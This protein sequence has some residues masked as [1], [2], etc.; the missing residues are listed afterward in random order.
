MS[1]KRIQHDQ[2]HWQQL[3]EQQASSGLSG[4]AFCRQQDIRYANF[5]S[6]RKKLQIP[7]VH[8]EVSAQSAF[9]ELTAPAQV[10][11]V[12]PRQQN[13][14]NES[15]VFVELSLGSGIE[16]RITRRD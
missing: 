6:W 13:L 1:T 7:K 15:T 9:I 10:A 2:T 12:A 16:L 11:S 14:K 4:A 8:S 3:V 5:M